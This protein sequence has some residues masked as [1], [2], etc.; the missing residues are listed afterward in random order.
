MDADL[1]PYVGGQTSTDTVV[2][3]LSLE[4]IQLIID[5]MIR[6]RFVVHTSAV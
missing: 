3:R 2:W 5:D 4:M 1:V 6:D